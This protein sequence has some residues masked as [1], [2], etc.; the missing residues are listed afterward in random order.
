MEL[1]EQLVHCTAQERHNV[2]LALD[3]LD[4]VGPIGNVHHGGRV[5]DENDKVRNQ[6]LYCCATTRLSPILRIQLRQIVSE[7]EAK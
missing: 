7:S 3:E 5:R 6:G 2:L 4:T 1:V